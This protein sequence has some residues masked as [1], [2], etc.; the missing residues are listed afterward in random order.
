MILISEWKI[1]EIML[2][3]FWSNVYS[4][5]MPQM[6]KDEGTENVLIVCR[7][8]NKNLQ[9]RQIRIIMFWTGDMDV[10]VGSIPILNVIRIK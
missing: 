7:K 4:V 2:I 8:Q 9:T 5:N 1:S 10:R 3:C 6:M